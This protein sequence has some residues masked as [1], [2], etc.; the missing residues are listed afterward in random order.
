[1]KVLNKN[2]IK[3][4]QEITNNAWPASC[5]YFM[6]GWIIRFNKGVTYRAN[7][8]LP[9]NWWGENLEESVQK[10][11][12]Y[13]TQTNLTSKFMLHDNYEPNGLEALLL[14]RFYKIIMPTSVMGTKTRN[15]PNLGAYS[16]F[17]IQY[18]ND[19]LPIWYPALIKLSP[20][21]SSEKMIVIAEIIDR[22]IIPKKRFFYITDN[23]EIIGAMLAVV[24]GN[25]MGLLNLA[26]EEHSK[27]KGVATT[28]I[29][30]A[31][32]WALS[33]NVKYVYLQVEN[34]NTPA[35]NLYQKLGFQTWYTYRYYEKNV[36]ESA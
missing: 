22:I 17:N 5:N 28:L 31:G 6:D 14:D 24:D 32:E 16:S 9:L 29:K 3:R 20:W 21:R 15:L 23:G 19:R 18:T 27:R 26:V 30:S 2:F 7:S 11:E 8:V 36:K 34:T 1:M 33:Q 25:F 4:V 10:V 35:I 13:Y 12:K